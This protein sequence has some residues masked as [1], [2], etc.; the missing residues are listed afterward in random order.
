M[1]STKANSSV[2]STTGSNTYE[3][4]V[5]AE[6]SVEPRWV[7]ATENTFT[8]DGLSPGEKVKMAVYGK[9]FDKLSD[10]SNVVVQRTG[11]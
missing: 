4:Q 8:L 11:E 3:I 5:I 6:T 10:A 2:T 9:S 7:E 1:R